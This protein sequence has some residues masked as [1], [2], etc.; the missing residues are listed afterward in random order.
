[1]RRSRGQ[2]LPAGYFEDRLDPGFYSTGIIIGAKSRDNGLA[3][4]PACDRV[5]KN[6]LKPVSDLNADFSVIA[7]N[8]QDDAVV[9]ALLSYFPVLGNLDAKILKRL[10]SQTGDCEDSYLMAGLLFKASEPLVQSSG[11]LRRH[12]SSVII[13]AA[14]ERRHLKGGGEEWCR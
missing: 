13:D 4:Y 6:S 3:Y 5:G 9:E 1:M 2:R 7:D 10:P 8:E 12:Q 14:V 11:A